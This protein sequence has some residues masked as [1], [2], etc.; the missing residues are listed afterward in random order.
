MFRGR[1]AE[2]HPRPDEGPLVQLIDSEGSPADIP[3]LKYVDMVTAD[4]PRPSLPTPTAG[5]DKSMVAPTDGQILLPPTALVAN[6]HKVGLRPLDGAGGELFPPAI[7]RRRSTGPSTPRPACMGAM[8]AL[9]TAGVD[10]LFSDF[11]LAV[12]ARKAFLA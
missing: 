5:P 9:Y 2:D 7:A 6:A 1:A 8:F 10:G 12:D 11:G 3:D 4:G